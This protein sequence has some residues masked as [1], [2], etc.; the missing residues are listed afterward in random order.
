MNA[1]AR[2]PGDAAAHEQVGDAL[3]ER[4]LVGRV[5]E[6]HAPGGRGRRARARSRRA[7]A[8]R[9]RSRGPRRRRSRAA[10]PAPSA[11]TIRVVAMP[12]AIS[13]ATYGKRT[14][15]A[16]RTSDRPATRG[17]AR[18]ASPA[19]GDRRRAAACGGTSSPPSPSPTAPLA[20]SRTTCTGSRTRVNA[21]ASPRASHAGP[22]AA[23]ALQLPMPDCKFMKDGLR[24]PRHDAHWPVKPPQQHDVRTRPWNSKTVVTNS[25]ASPE[26][27]SGSTDRDP[28]AQYIPRCT[29]AIS[30]ARSFVLPAVL[31][32][33]AAAIAI[34]VAIDF[35]ARFL[36][37]Q[38]K[39]ITGL[40]V[41]L[42][43]NETGS[44]R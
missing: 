43:A 8:R 27:T 31:V 18:A 23:A 7:P 21:A 28:R 33:A 24:I 20:P 4:G 11:I 32:A 9:A 12:L 19:A 22:A 29:R 44:N 17:T 42:T 34:T 40:T 41:N 14:P 26:P 30:R 39:P 13:P 10:R 36:D 38:N 25:V 2:D 6:V 3:L 5:D 15:C 35:C 16:S 1:E 37:A